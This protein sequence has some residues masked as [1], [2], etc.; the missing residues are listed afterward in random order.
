[1]I[2]EE[3]VPAE[4]SIAESSVYVPVPTSSA[5]E[6]MPSSSV[7][8]GVSLSTFSTVSASVSVPTYS[9]NGTM[10]GSPS[11]TAIPTQFPEEGAASRF[12]SSAAL[13]AGAIA[14]ALFV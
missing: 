6:Y 13:I 2:S 12:G 8:V 5:V 1:M 4:T 7:V 11:A 10:T 9:S 14:V 3:P